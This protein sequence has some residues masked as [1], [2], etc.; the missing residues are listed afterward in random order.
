MKLM[1]MNFLYD[2]L[3]YVELIDVDKV[4]AECTGV[5]SDCSIKRTKD[6]LPKIYNGYW[7]VL[8]RSVTS[9]DGEVEIH[10]T[11][12]Q[13]YVRKTNLSDF[14]YNKE[15]YYWVINNYLYFPNIEWDAVK[16]DAVFEDDISDY[17]CNGNPCLAGQE[18]QL[19]VL[20][21][22]MNYVMDNVKNDIYGMFNIQ[23]DPNTDLKNINR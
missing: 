20:D 21:N 4:E 17:K 10:P 7:D 5:K 23:P 22:I 14:K 16:I 1:R 2:V 12:P 6:P 11:S 13:S 18:L 9:L 19:P 8:I 15:K 3:P